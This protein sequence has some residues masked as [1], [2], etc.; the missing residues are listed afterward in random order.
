MKSWEHL[1]DNAKTQM[2]DNIFEMNFELHIEVCLYYDSCASVLTVANS[3]LL[4]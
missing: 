3:S 1:S 4:V 2:K